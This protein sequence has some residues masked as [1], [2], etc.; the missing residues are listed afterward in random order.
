[1]TPITDKLELEIESAGKRDVP[2]RIYDIMRGMERSNND[3]L[4]ALQ[5]TCS[6]VDSFL[7]GP[8][9]DADFMDK[10]LMQARAAIAKATK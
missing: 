5:E 3:L 6:I 2:V 1:M 7:N 4:E 8:G 10:V 9:E